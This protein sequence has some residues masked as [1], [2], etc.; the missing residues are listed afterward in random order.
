MVSQ[1]I[2][3][4]AAIRPHLRF[5]EFSDQGIAQEH[6]QAAPARVS[7]QIHTFS[8]HRQRDHLQDHLIAQRPVARHLGHVLQDVVQG[9]GQPFVK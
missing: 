8:P 5:V 9:H 4:F 7:L 2:W 1:V 6:P 3:S